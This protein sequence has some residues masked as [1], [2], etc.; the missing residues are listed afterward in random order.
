MNELLARFNDDGDDVQIRKIG[1]KPNY[2]IAFDG[3]QHLEVSIQFD[4]VEIH[5]DGFEF[6][7]R[8]S[9]NGVRMSVHTGSIE[10]GKFGAVT[11]WLLENGS[12]HT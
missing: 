11:K 12:P 5:D 4:A 8:R 9:P 7:R 2:T 6:Y 10:R 3:P 1:T